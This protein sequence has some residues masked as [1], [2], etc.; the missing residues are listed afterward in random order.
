MQIRIIVHRANFTWGSSDIGNIEE[1]TM[2]S[3]TTQRRKARQR[4]DDRFQICGDTPDSPYCQ[5]QV[6]HIQ[7]RSE[8]GSNDLDNL[9]TLCDLC[10][11][12]CHWH[13]GPA[14]CGLSSLSP[15]QR[16]EAR[17]VLVEAQQTFQNYFFNRAE[18][19]VTGA[20]I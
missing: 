20:G 4:D 16:R 6:H 12:V 18:C 2:P 7:L 17:A 11:A 19:E 9:A 10:H 15:G 5:L 14:W 8:G 1:T 13:M 3:W